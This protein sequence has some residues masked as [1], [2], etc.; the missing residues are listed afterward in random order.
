MKD[1]QGLMQFWK[2]WIIDYLPP[3][4][5]TSHHLANAAVQKKQKEK[6]QPPWAFRQGF[7]SRG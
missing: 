5:L 1:W 4:T 2:D 7:V 6:A 3:V